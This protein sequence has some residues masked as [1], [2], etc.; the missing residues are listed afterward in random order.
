MDS[1]NPY[2]HP[3]HGRRIARPIGPLV[4]LHRGNVGA[5]W[6]SFDDGWRQCRLQDGE[7]WTPRYIHEWEKGKVTIYYWALASEELTCSAIERACSLRQPSWA[8]STGGLLQSA[9]PLLPVLL[10]ASGPAL[11]A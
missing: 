11:T 1:G 3:T 10:I 6:S 7:G 4:G 9:K 5:P 2:Q 8:C